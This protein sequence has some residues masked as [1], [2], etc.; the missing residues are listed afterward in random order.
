MECRPLNIE[1]M[2]VAPGSIKSNIASNA[3]HRFEMAP[4][5]LY[6]SYTNQIIA[7]MNFSQGPGSMPTA[8]MAEQVVEAALSKKLPRYITMGGNST[9][10]HILSW[11]PRG[12]VLWLFWKKF[13][14]EWSWA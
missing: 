6:K 12:L 11:L 13:S 10:L 1:V 7:R 4:D 8:K 9:L 14:G 5:S 2:L 3:A